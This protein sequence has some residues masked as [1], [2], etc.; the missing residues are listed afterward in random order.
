M[1][2]LVW[3]QP[4]TLKYETGVSNGVFCPKDRDAETWNGLVSVSLDNTEE[5]DV[6]T[7]IDGMAILKRKRRPSIFGTIEA[8]TYP[9]SF[10]ETIFSARSPK[11]FDMSY[12]TKTNDSEQI[13]LLYNILLESSVSSRNQEDAT[14]Y[15]WEFS[16]KPARFL[17]DIRSSHLII[18]VDV[19]YDSVLE[20]LE[21]VLYGSDEV[22][23]RMPKP[24]EVLDIFERN[25]VL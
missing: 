18:E 4:G 24:L 17:G 9:D 22:T 3:H 10:Y 11:I 23:P 21:G 8:F 2:E 13:H 12:R 25:S 1:A 7:Y 14:L 5:S 15:S 19:V 20:E 16:T 6:S